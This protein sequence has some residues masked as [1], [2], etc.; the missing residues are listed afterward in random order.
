MDSA[1]DRKLS[2]DNV[3]YSVAVS[4]PGLLNY[5]PPSWNEFHSTAMSIIRVTI[6]MIDS[7]LSLIAVLCRLSEFLCL[8]LW[9][10]HI[11]VKE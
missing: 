10:F 6:V 1:H 2:A 7:R 5:I 3:K 11:F 9:L 8:F 4:K